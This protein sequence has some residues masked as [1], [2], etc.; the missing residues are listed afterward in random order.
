MAPPAQ[1][2]LFARKVESETYTTALLPKMAA[3]EPL[4][5]ASFSSKRHSETLSVE[6]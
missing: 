5:D 2:A 1:L 3:P 4:L 6:R